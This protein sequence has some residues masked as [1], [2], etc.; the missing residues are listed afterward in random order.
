MPRHH[1]VCWR[2][3][4]LLQWTGRSGDVHAMSSR[5]LYTVTVP[6]A[7]K[8]DRTPS[9][10]ATKSDKTE[11]LWFGPPS[12]SPSALVRQFSYYHKSEH[13]QAVVSRPW[14]GRLVWRWAVNAPARLACVTDVLSSAPHTLSP[15]STRR[16][17]TVTAKL[18]IALVL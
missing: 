9:E 10:I 12:P 2:Q 6:L 8:V 13:H 14:S 7:T 15:S 11:V 16:D 4:R 17:V 18:V 1:S 3:A 5:M